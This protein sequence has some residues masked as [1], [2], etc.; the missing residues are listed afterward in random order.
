M[1]FLTIQFRT[2][3]LAPLSKCKN[4]RRLDLRLTQT[5]RTSSSPGTNIYDLLRSIRNLDNLRVLSFPPLR[6]LYL[7]SDNVRM[8]MVQ[9]PR[10]LTHLRLSGTLP[11]TTGWWQEIAS[12]WPETLTSLEFQDCGDST[13]MMYWGVENIVF[14]RIDSLRI[15]GDRLNPHD[16]HLMYATLRL[17][18]YLRFLSLPALLI[19][20]QSPWCEGSRNMSL[21]RL[22]ITLSSSDDSVNFSTLPLLSD[23]ASGMELLW[24]IRL[25]E[26]YAEDDIRE[27]C[28]IVDTLLKKRAKER[29]EA[30]G[31]VICEPEDAGIILFE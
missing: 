28:Q 31:H 19:G 5:H 20:K 11:R 10:N 4:L 7:D 21:E 14:P 29:N 24:Q 2:S 16:D 17:F 3:S 12:R 18:P 9:W 6:W 23:L 27:D 30:A 15:S 8:A 25:H 26:S 1:Q 13:P 22:E